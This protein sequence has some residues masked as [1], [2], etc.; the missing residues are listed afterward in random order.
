MSNVQSILDLN[1]EDSPLVEQYD[2]EVYDIMFGDLVLRIQKHQLES[3]ISQF[4]LDNPVLVRVEGGVAQVVGG[5]EWVPV[6][7]RDYD[8][9]GVPEA[10]TLV[11]DEG[12]RYIER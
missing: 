12:Q 5:P 1:H 4:L 10:E 2:E 6:R 3:V 7:I 9:E 11:D 8:T